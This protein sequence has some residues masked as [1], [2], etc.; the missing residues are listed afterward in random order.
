[1]RPVLGRSETRAD[2]GKARRRALS[3]GMRDDEDKVE[4]NKTGQG[5]KN[6]ED[7]LHKKVFFPSSSKADALAWQEELEYSGREL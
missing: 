6:A 1:M 5:R 2:S 7:V 3:G 4:R